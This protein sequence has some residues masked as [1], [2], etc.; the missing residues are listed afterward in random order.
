M[1]TL[2]PRR[3]GALLGLAGGT[4]DAL[5][6]TA[7]GVTFTV[8]GHDA[9]ALVWLYLA[10]SLGALGYVIGWL[11]ESRRAERAHAAA[12]ADTQGRLARLTTLAALGQLAGTVAHEVRNP[13]AVIRSTVQTAREDLEDAIRD[14]TP[15]THGAHDTH[16]TYGSPATP[17][18]PATPTIEGTLTTLDFT[19]AEI[20]RLDRVIDGVLGLAR[21]PG[22]ARAPLPVTALFDRAAALARRLLADRALSLTA[23]PIDATLDADPDLACQA[24]LDLV[25]NAADATP[26]GGAITLT[27]A[28][29]PEGIA[30]S[31]AD[32]GPGVPQA[33]RARVFEPFYT[34]RPHGTGLGLAV[35]H[36]IARAHGGHVTLDDPPGGGARFTLHLPRAQGTTP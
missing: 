7:L 3:L 20:D 31:V 5:G 17:A 35:V 26:P 4:L 16:G 1:N 12:L 32:T 29:T 8:A 13:L 9:L 36:H 15:G 33:H 14:A 27:A 23:H 25:A 34:T 10:L 2:T 21:P 6:A 18:T 30:L 28:A 11:V 24:L 22:P 19:L